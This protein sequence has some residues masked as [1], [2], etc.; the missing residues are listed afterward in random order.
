MWKIT[1]YFI[2]LIPFFLTTAC[3]KESTAEPQLDTTPVNS[4][5][6]AVILST[7][8]YTLGYHYTIEPYF[9][10]TREV[11]FESQSPSYTTED[12]TVD[13]YGRRAFY[14]LICSAQGKTVYQADY[15]NI[16]YDTYDRVI[17]F[18]VSYSF[19]ATDNSYD[20][21]ITDIT[22]DNQGQTLEYTADI[23]ADVNGKQVT[24]LLTYP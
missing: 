15:A 19:H 1:I 9:T 24:G 8:A 11:S 4:V 7:K 12:L 13:A 17:R 5:A 20:F 6:E 10:F 22:R 23:T 16:K 2:I 21:D 3:K 18:Q 14:S